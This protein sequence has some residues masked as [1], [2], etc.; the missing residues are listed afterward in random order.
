MQNQ[1]ET[2]LRDLLLRAIQER[3]GDEPL[4][5]GRIIELTGNP[6]VTVE[7]VRAGKTFLFTTEQLVRATQRLEITRQQ[8]EH[9]ASFFR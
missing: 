7:D 4:T 6:D 3:I 5:R 2:V 8:V 1:K 9:G